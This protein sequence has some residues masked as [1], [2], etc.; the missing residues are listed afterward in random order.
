MLI[1]ALS[2]FPPSAGRAAVA[3]TGA[4]NILIVLTDDQR[5]MGSL[6]VM[7]YTRNWLEAGGTDFPNAFVTTPLC[8]PSRAALLTGMYAHNTGI[9][10]DHEDPAKLASIQPLTMES[11]L[12]PNGYST[13]LFGKYF[14]GWP[15]TM[16]P[17]FFD[18][19]A[20]TPHVR[21]TGA[22]WNIDGVTQTLNTYTTTVVQQQALAFLDWT[23]QSGQSSKPWFLY[24]APMAPHMPAT[25][26]PR[27]ANAPLPPLHLSPGMKQN[28]F[29]R[30]TPFLKGLHAPSVFAIQKR[31]VPMLRSLMSVDQMVNEL[32]LKLQAMGELNNTLV[33]FASD[34]GYQW[35]EHGIL[36]KCDPYL[37]SVKVPLIIRWP[38]HF[39]AG[40]IDNRLVALLDIAPTIFHATGLAPTHPL[41]GIDLL[42]PHANRKELLLEYNRLPVGGWPSW[43]ALVSTTFEYVEYGANGGN[44][45]EYYNLRR[46]PY[47]LV[48]L[49]H[50]GNRPKP[51]TAAMSQ[52]LKGYETCAGATCPK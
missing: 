25:P 5:A 43:D 27:F 29:S 50:D 39:K 10:I 36:G 8:C 51:S 33:I 40:A 18:K 13:G 23:T 49:L 34:N 7:P 52:R 38:G 16:N 31:R 26:E 41:D 44:F 14:N 46:D 48:N 47:Q 11:V 2:G 15:N 1:L 19:W 28:N 30:M 32:M 9:T 24:V 42:D 20:V 6:D 17:E 3:P 4:P 12:Q 45:R 21:F 37:E 22:D 35:G